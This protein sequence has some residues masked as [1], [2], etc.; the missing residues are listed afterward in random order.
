MMK[1]NHIMGYRERLLL[2]VTLFLSTS[3]LGYID[4]SKSLHQQKTQTELVYSNN[5]SSSKNAVLFNRFIQFTGKKGALFNFYEYIKS[6]LLT[7]KNLTKTKQDHFS[8]KE[9]YPLIADCFI[10]IYQNPHHS[11]EGIF[12]TKIK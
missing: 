7:L 10:Q 2:F 8:I 6:A 1:A 11:K 12:T 5:A 3:F 9:Y 4:N